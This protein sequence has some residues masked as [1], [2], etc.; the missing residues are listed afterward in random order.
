[1]KRLKKLGIETVEDLIYHKPS[2]YEDWSLI[3]PISKVQAG[4]KVT[5]VGKLMTIQPITS[6][7][8][9][10]LQ[11]ARVMD[12]N[13]EIQVVWFNQRYLI[14]TMRVGQWYSLAG[15]AEE[16]NGQL[17][18]VAP[19][20]EKINQ[21]S[22]T[23]NKSSMESSL[24]HTGRLVPVYPETYG[25]SS[26]WLRSR[27]NMAL[28]KVLPVEDWQNLE[29][30]RLSFRPSDKERGE[31]EKSQTFEDFSSSRAKL[32]EGRNDNLIDLTTALYQ[33]HF[34]DSMEMAEK[35]QKRLA[36][37][38][39]L[40]LHLENLERRGE[41]KKNRTAVRIQNSESEIRNFII[42]LPFKLTKA[43]FRVIDEIVEDLTRDK[44]MNRLLEGDV[45]SGKTVVAAAGIYL[46]VKA[47]MQTALM[48]PTEV[49]AQQHYEVL[50]NLLG[51][52]ESSRSLPEKEK[53]VE[54]RSIASQRRQIKVVLQTGRKKFVKKGEDEPFD[55]IVG[56]HA[57]LSETINFDKLGL[58]VIDE[59]HRF[60]VEQ[61]AKLVNKGLAPHVLSMTATPIPRTVALT[62]YGELD[63][64]VLDEMPPG[65]MPVK[66]WLVPNGKREAAYEWIKEQILSTDSAIRDPNKNTEYRIQETEERRQSTGDRGKNTRNLKLTTRNQVFIVCPFIEPSESLATVKAAR[67]EFEKL[68]Q[69]FNDLELNLLH[70]KLK[71]RRKI[72]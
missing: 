9:K 67:E 55:V 12:E 51:N 3:S 16:F 21:I 2:R 28:E 7:Y 71:E 5:V 53:N 26:K 39:L 14:N 19:E 10:S 24:V 33:I 69:V 46:T 59:Q 38:E 34:P 41:W 58:V 35:A 18:L 56:T 54:T 36:H 65:R 1:V 57:L 17:S 48:A 47:G 37:D 27:I 52:S 66:T 30:Y 22:G 32:S 42:N 45:G 43:Q 8:G 44:P 11:I 15:K 61:R 13:R 20:W 60:G 62:M 63:L 4:E 70:G 23:Q 29:V 31:G 50:K 72:R 6:K 40:I 64:S 49:L 68:K 25:V